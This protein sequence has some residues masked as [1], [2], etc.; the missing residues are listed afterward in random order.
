MQSRPEELITSG[1]YFV[2]RQDG[3]KQLRTSS[4]DEG[5]PDVTFLDPL[6]ALLIIMDIYDTVKSA[7]FICRYL[8]QTST[9]REFRKGG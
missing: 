9:M 1:N 8:V 7:L 5:H 6:A 4:D 2:S 3:V